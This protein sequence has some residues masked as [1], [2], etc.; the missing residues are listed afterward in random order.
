MNHSIQ[1][2]R[3]LY[4]L[5]KDTGSFDQRHDIVTSYTDGRTHNSSDMSTSEIITLINNLENHHRDTGAPL[6]DFQKGDRMRKRVLSLF[7]QYGYAKYSP[8]KKKM[9]IDF[10]R[11]DGWM[12]KF[13]YLHKKLNKY[14]YAELPKL[15]TQVERLVHKYIQTAFSN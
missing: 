2:H 1:L 14:K 13:G 10:D 9:I 12:L 15:V 7:H 8:E 3:K 6:N 5:L 4:K 11:L